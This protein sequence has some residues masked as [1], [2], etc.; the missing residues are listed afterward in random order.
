M[1]LEP[2]WG[3]K[4]WQHFPKKWLPRTA[5]SRNPSEMDVPFRISAH[6]SRNQQWLQHASQSHYNS[7]WLG[8]EN[9]MNRSFT[10]VYT[11]SNASFPPDISQTYP[12]SG[13][14]AFTPLS[15]KFLH[16]LLQFLHRTSRIL[17]MYS[18]ELT[19]NRITHWKPTLFR[20]SKGL[21][22]FT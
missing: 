19:G 21:I 22:L 11:V 1:V 13:E 9:H 7:P 12:P 15:F 18:Y 4:A 16:N 17:H 5:T 3:T 6:L 10:R 2:S 20:S 14:I 8:L